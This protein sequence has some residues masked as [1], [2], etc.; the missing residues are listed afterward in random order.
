MDTT[1]YYCPV[2]HQQ[3]LV[4]HTLAEIITTRE[5][6]HDAFNHQRDSE[7]LGH[8][9][10]AMWY[11]GSTLNPQ[12]HQPAQRC[13]EATDGSQP[14]LVNTTTHNMPAHTTKDMT[15]SAVT[16]HHADTKE[17]AAQ[18]L[19]EWYN[20]VNTDMI[21][22]FLDAWGQ[23]DRPSWMGSMQESIQGVPGEL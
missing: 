11:S 7:C 19:C 12:P 18:I 1:T 5:S 23:T 9:L 10:S 13:L 17:D 6:N 4:K 15:P 8:S 3:K 20:N 22:Y 14:T 16:T 2:I 21:G